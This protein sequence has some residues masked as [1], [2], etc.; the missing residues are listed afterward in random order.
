[1]TPDQYTAWVVTQ[2]LYPQTPE[3]LAFY[4]LGLCGEAGEVAEKMKKLFRDGTWPGAAAVVK[5]LGDVLWYATRIAEKCGY[6]LQ[7]V[8]DMNVEKLTDRNK[9]GV[10]RGSG[11]NR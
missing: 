9:R 8:M 10:S 4:T 11:D 6:T 2:D 5:E 3:S 7:D 1:M